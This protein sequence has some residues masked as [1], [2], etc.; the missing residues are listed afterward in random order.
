MTLEDP[1]TQ[2]MAVLSLV[3]AMLSASFALWLE[4]NPKQIE[5]LGMI[6]QIVGVWGVWQDG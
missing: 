6:G 1:T 4:K 3:T 5:G 2:R